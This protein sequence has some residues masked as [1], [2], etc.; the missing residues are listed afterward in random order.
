MRVVIT[1]RPLPTTPSDRAPSPW[2]S[3]V[4]FPKAWRAWREGSELRVRILTRAPYT[5][6]FLD[7]DS[8]TIIA[9]AHQRRRPG[10][11]IERFEEKPRR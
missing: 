1:S 8:I 2:R 7:G 5:I 11:W 9:V 10:Y 6:V 3:S 4:K